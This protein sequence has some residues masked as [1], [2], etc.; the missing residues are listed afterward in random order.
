MK[1]KNIEV[2]KRRGFHPYFTTQPNSIV[3]EYIKKFSKKNDTILDSFC[4]SGVT[5]LES[6]ILNRNSIGIDLSHFACFISNLSTQKIS[7]LKIVDKN[8]RD[9]EKSV[10]NKIVGQYN[11]KE[12]NIKNL[13]QPK[14]ILLPKNADCKYLKDIFTKNNYSCLVVLINKINELEDEKIRNLFRGIFS[15]V[16]HRA[17]RT[18]FMIN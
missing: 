2:K 11:N 12:I 18:F 4:G 14:N 16:L 5:L 15:G 1:F 13:W 3:S 10:K 9:I 6:R 8:F 17:S 7:N